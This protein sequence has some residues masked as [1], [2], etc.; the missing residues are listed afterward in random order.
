M[1]KKRSSVIRI[2]ERYQKAKNKIEKEKR[3]EVLKENFINLVKVMNPEDLEI[4][5]ALK[6]YGN[7]FLKFVAEEI[8]EQKAIEI[9]KSFNI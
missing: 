1:K 8:N 9:K 4:Y 2:F 5:E 6:V 3:A 7:D